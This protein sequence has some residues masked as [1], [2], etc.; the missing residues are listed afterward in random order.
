M[1]VGVVVFWGGIHQ[2]AGILKGIVRFL[3]DRQ[4]AR[5]IAPQRQDVRDV[6]LG[7]ALENLPDIRFAMA[8]AGQVRRA[9]SRLVVSLIRT[10]R[11]WVRSRVVPP[12]P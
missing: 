6:V 11:L 8:D 4:V 5:R 1:N 12:A 9:G 7:V 10:T 3:V 2:I